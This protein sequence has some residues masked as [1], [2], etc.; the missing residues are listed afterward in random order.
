MLKISLLFKTFADHEQT[1]REFLALR[2]WNIQ[3]IVFT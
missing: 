1:T 3:G 2:M